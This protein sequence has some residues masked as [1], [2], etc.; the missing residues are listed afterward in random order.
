MIGVARGN[1]QYDEIVESMASALEAAAEEDWDE[2]R[3]EELPGPG[4]G[5][6]ADYLSD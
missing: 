5:L 2:N 6:V 3:D 1:A 4:Y